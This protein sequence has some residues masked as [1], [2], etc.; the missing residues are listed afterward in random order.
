MISP[1]FDNLFLKRVEKKLETGEYVI[2]N[3][4]I[5]EQ[6]RGLYIVI[7]QLLFQGVKICTGGEY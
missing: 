7:K 5:K 3:N 1:V 6:P 2:T 4:I